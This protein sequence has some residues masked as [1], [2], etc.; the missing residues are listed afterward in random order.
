MATSS[1]RLDFREIPRTGCDS[2][3]ADAVF[4]AART[5]RR[6]PPPQPDA[7]DRVTCLVDCNSL[8]VFRRNPIAA[9]DDRVDVIFTNST[10]MIAGMGTNFTNK[11]SD[12][13][14]G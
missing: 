12:V 3:T 9:D 4:T 11:P 1:S 2:I 6:D 10:I 13:R 7:D 8:E 5:Q 14:T